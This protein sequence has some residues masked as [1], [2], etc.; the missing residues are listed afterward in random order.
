MIN[1]IKKLRNADHML[2]PMYP[3]RNT[4]IYTILIHA[5][6]CNN[7]KKATTDAWRYRPKRRN[8]SY[9][10]RAFYCRYIREYFANKYWTKGYR[11]HKTKACWRRISKIWAVGGKIGYASF[12]IEVVWNLLV[13][14]VDMRPFMVGNVFTLLSCRCFRRLSV[15]RLIIVTCIEN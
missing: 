6:Y 12:I 11:N 5:D 7:F 13:E 1:N 15:T 8:E 4:D 2:T 9:P 10:K 3:K 14:D